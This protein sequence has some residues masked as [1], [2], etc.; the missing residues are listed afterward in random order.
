[1]SYRPVESIRPILAH[2]FI[3]VITA[4]SLDNFLA[5]NELR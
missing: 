2:D 4:A 1:M 5:I 3:A